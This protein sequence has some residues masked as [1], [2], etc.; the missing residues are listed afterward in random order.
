MATFDG[1]GA[2]SAEECAGAAAILWDLDGQARLREVAREV[3][4]LPPGTGAL[5]A[6]AA[7]ATLALRLLRH[8]PRADRR[9]R[10]TGDALCVVRHCTGAQGLSHMG[11]RGLL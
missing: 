6:E 3:R 2:P 4:T 5:V 1:S 8:A 11:A 7:G 10:I 9:A